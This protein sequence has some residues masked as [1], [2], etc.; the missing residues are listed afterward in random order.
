MCAV[1]RVVIVERARSYVPEIGLLGG[2]FSCAARRGGYRLRE[3]R[4]DMFV[5]VERSGGP[6][7][8]DRIRLEHGFALPK[9]RV[10]GVQ[11]A[12]RFR[13]RLHGISRDVS[14]SGARAVHRPRASL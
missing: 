2:W 9:T 8:F 5:G 1:L 14:R 12:P 13:V 4:P 6:K 7:Q 11:R 3:N 10:A